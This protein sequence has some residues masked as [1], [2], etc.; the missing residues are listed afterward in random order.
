MILAKKKKH[1]IIGL[2]A[3]TIIIIGTLIGFNY[4]QKNILINTN[5]YINIENI[6]FP[7]TTYT[8]KINNK[9]EALIKSKTVAATGPNESSIIENSKRVII[10]KENMNII[11]EIA[12]SLNLNKKNNYKLYY[13]NTKYEETIKYYIIM[14]TAEAINKISQ[15]NNNIGSCELNAINQTLKE[16]NNIAD[17]MKLIFE[18]TYKCKS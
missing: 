11:N 2:I 7:S 6:A 3:L 5:Y 8:I 1:I 4:Y 10:T 14:Y 16:N 9:G 15:V 18:A 12:L 17:Y 13:S